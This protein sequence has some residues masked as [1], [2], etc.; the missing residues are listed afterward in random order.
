MIRTSWI[1]LVSLPLVLTGCT[2]LG[3]WD[4]RIAPEDATGVVF[5]DRNRNGTQDWWE[6][7]IGGVRVSNGREI[8]LTGPGGRYQLD[9]QGDTSVFV[10]K[11]RDWMTPVDEMNLPQFF[12]IHRPNG[13]PEGLKYPGVAPTPDT[14]ES[15]D[16]ALYRRP[17][18]KSFDVVVFGDTQTSSIEEINYLAHDAIEEVAGFDA[19]FGISLG[20]IVGDNIGDLEKVNQAIALI[21]LPWYNLPGNHDMNFYAQT[22]EYSLETYNRIYGPS[23]YSFDYGPVHFL[24]L[25]SIIAYKG[26]KER[27]VYHE[28][29]DAKQLEFIRNDL[30]LLDKDQLVV[31]AMHGPENQFKQSR[32]RFFEILEKHPQALSVAGHDHQ[33]MHLFLDSEYDWHGP[34]PHHLYVSGAVSGAW[35]TG[36]PDETGIPHTMMTNG[37]P[38]GYSVISFDGRD[39]KI[40]FKAFRRPA[41][42]QMNISAPEE[43]LAEN[44]ADTEVLV[45]VFAG[46]ER[47]KVEMKFTE[48]GKWVLMER[49]SRKDPYFIALREQEDKFNFPRANWS[50]NASYSRHIWKA[51][52]PE[53]VSKGAHLIHIRSKD[54]FGEVQTGKRLI[55]IK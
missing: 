4:K 44:A 40:R 48:N 14:P 33:T 53:D 37:V 52:L 7:G 6:Q 45:N 29:L 34:R 5:H 2:R 11:P 46:S 12:Y 43:V 39:Y 20:D 10:I 41:D 13:S 21:G 30:A 23:Y 49:V 26:E 55:R 24:M 42:Y 32:R 9:I 47:S 3:L 22:D 28:G 16:F 27:L 50:K 1:L 54:M 35:W 19:A 38:N 17:E 15:I 36:V 18:P 25:D 8:V 31:L 51:F